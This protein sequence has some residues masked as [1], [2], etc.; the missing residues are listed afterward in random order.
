MQQF[1]S[2]FCFCRCWSEIKWKIV[3]LCDK[4]HLLIASAR[5]RSVH[6]SWLPQVKQFIEK[7]ECFEVST[8]CAEVF[9]VG[10]K[11]KAFSARSAASWPPDASRCI[12]LLQQLW[13]RLQ[14]IFKKHFP[15]PHSLTH[16]PAFTCLP[17]YFTFSSSPLFALN[18]SFLDLSPFSLY[19]ISLF[20][21]FTS[22]SPP[23]HMAPLCI[24]IAF[25]PS[26]TCSV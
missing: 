18:L 2:E 16:S 22:F 21:P 8:F 7:N 10:L 24:F 3:L 1:H 12:R 9:F 19:L 4:R 26:H 20:Q 23:S 13:V 11:L 25:L 6:S 15:N 14:V 17:P 5:R